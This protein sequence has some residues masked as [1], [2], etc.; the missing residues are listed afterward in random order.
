[1]IMATAAVVYA[2]EEESDEEDGQNSMPGFE[3]A[4]AL[5]ALGAAR[6]AKS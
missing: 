1:M 5:A 4:L 3:L 2:E 6:L